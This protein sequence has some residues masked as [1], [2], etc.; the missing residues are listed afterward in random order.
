[1]WGEVQRT[2]IGSFDLTSVV[3][4]PEKLSQ[5][6]SGGSNR[7][8]A[9][10]RCGTLKTWSS[11]A[12]SNGEIKQTNWFFVVGGLTMGPFG[13]IFGTGKINVKESHQKMWKSKNEFV[14][15]LHILP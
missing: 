7:T 3:L 5:P 4:S 15:F 13:E 12:G 10:D 2:E 14:S 11:F 6:N 9:V 1:V 8:D